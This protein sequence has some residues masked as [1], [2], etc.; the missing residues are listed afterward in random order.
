[1]DPKLRKAI[2]AGLDAADAIY[3][4]I[5]ENPDGLCWGDVLAF[6]HQQHKAV[7]AARRAMEKER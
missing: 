7:K 4:A 3:T 6:A 1:M 5:Y 2:T